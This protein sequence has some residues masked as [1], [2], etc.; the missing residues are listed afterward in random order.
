MLATPLID[1]H[2]SAEA[3]LVDFAGWEMPV[4]YTSIVEE[5]HYTRRHASVFD[6]SH[7]GR[8]EFRGPDAGPHVP[9]GRRHPRRRDRLAA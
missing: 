6:V 1:F 2:R 8:V 5:H 9:R 3:R 4:V 7:M